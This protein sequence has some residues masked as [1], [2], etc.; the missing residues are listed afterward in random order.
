[1]SSQS[2][3]LGKANHLGQLAQEIMQDGGINAS[4]WTQAVNAQK[5]NF[6]FASDAPNELRDA[7]Q[8][9]RSAHDPTTENRYDT[10]L[11]RNKVALG[12]AIG[13]AVFVGLLMIGVGG[14]FAAELFKPEFLSDLPDVLTGASEFAASVPQEF[15]IGVLAGLAVGAVATA[16]AI[17]LILRQ[18]RKMQAGK[19]A[20][21]EGGVVQQFLDATSPQRP[22]NNLSRNTNNNPSNNNL[23][24]NTNNNP[25]NNNLSNNTNNPSNNTPK[26][27]RAPTLEEL[28]NQ[29][30]G[31]RWSAVRVEQ[32]NSRSNQPRATQKIKKRPGQASPLAGIFGST[33][34]RN[35]NQRRGVINRNDTV[36][37]MTETLFQQLNA[38]T[39]P[40][41]LKH[42][43]VESGSDTL[44]KTANTPQSRIQLMNELA[45]LQK[46]VQAISTSGHEN[47]NPQ[48]VTQLKQK[49]ALDLGARL[50]TIALQFS[51]GDIPHVKD[52]GCFTRALPNSTLERFEMLLER[53]RTSFA[54]RM[55]RI[56]NIDPLVLNK[57]ELATQ[58]KTKHEITS[59]IKSL[60]GEQITQIMNHHRLR[61]PTTSSK[62][63]GQYGRVLQNFQQQQDVVKLH[64]GSTRQAIHAFRTDLPHLIHR[65]LKTRLLSLLPQ[66]K[67]RVHT[68]LGNKNQNR[69]QGL[70]KVNLDKNAEVD[71]SA[72]R[73]LG[74]NMKINWNQSIKEDNL[75]GADWSEEEEE[76]SGWS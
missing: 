28:N 27:P 5:T 75:E 76:S 37:K 30:Q 51:Y 59:F 23:P 6:G 67:K 73:K 69:R 44:L 68:P 8:T 13:V 3:S 41:L 63:R 4:N 22:N 70:L 36:I 20:F 50:M 17:V 60:R 10:K 65:A 16:T 33:I 46:K 42:F 14:A 53:R 38:M 34:N 19:E 61:K 9:L 66:P 48:E 18:R 49:I 21:Q 74:A 58:A 12:I 39:I 7:M 54:L 45:S 62:G 25:S 31:R 15:Y 64:M 35:L 32:S 55:N 24:S 52:I 2:I 29:N 26:A 11:T 47:L 57:L 56:E 40:D 1:M 71:P 43:N 72:L